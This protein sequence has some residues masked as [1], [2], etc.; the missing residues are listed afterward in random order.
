MTGLQEEAKP[1]SDSGEQPPGKQ[2]VRSD[3]AA[4][5]DDASLEDPNAYRAFVRSLL[6]R[7]EGKMAAKLDDDVQTEI[8]KM[9]QLLA[10]MDREV[11][12]ANRVYFELVF[13]ILGSE[14]PNLLLAKSIRREI[15]TI[16]DRK[17]HGITHL[18]GY[19]CGNTRINAALSALVSASVLAFLFIWLT[20]AGHREMLRDVA[21]T[22]DLFAA[23]DAHSVML[24]L[25]AIHAAFIGGIVSILTRM[26]D[27]TT[28]PTQTPLLVYIAVFRKPFLAATFVVLV[29]SVLSSGLISFHG[30]DLA[31]ASAPYLAWVVGFLCGFS[32]R[33]AQDFVVSAG[34]RFSNPGP[35]D[36]RPSQPS[37]S[38]S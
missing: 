3:P 9:M 18:I 25:I 1:A 8:A 16:N 31:G 11:V 37:P 20:A 23:L 10:S 27:F 30:V 19:L 6:S 34:G 36:V 24:L 17:S 28:D 21:G 38:R 7:I 14:Q 4:C 5:F 33:F 2:L 13:D 26:G 12:A 22:S 29:F 35:P 15:G 32:E